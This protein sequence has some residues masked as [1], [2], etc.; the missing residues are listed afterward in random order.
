MPP[1]LYRIGSAPAA[2]PLEM[3]IMALFTS[4]CGSGLCTCHALSV[5]G[6]EVY[7]EEYT[8]L[9]GTAALFIPPPTYTYDCASTATPD[10]ATTPGYTGP[11][12]HCVTDPLAADI[13]PM[14]VP[15]VVVDAP[16]T[17]PPT[18]MTTTPSLA[19]PG[20]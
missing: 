17:T 2:V 4:D 6:F 12:C 10:S 16:P 14:M 18:K 3:T 1:T 11:A 13:K 7:C 8:L 20:L 15:L 9:Y 19:N 5:G